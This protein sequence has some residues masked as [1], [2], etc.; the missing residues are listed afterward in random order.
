MYCKSY[1]VPFVAGME[2]FAQPRHALDP[3]APHSTILQRYGVLRRAQLP[4]RPA[5]GEA[6]CAGRFCTEQTNR[7][8]SCCQEERTAMVDEPA[9]APALADEAGAAGAADAAAAAAG[10][11]DTPLTLLS[12]PLLSPS[13]GGGASVTEWY[14]RPTART[15]ASSQTTST[16][17]SELTE[18]LAALELARLRADEQREQARWQAEHDR[19]E[20]TRRALEE[21]EGR[22]REA[23]SAADAMRT[24]LGK[25]RTAESERSAELDVALASL[26]EARQLAAT[27]ASDA[28]HFRGQA[29]TLAAT[30]EALT[31][32]SERQAE[33]LRSLQA[34]TSEQRQAL[35]SAQKAYELTHLARHH[36][37]LHGAGSGAT[38]A[39]DRM[40][41]APSP[42]LGSPSTPSGSGRADG[43]VAS[44]LPTD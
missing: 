23:E 5:C 32:H 37:Q 3:A 36:A 38:A 26:K 39:V 15:D 13:S 7:S 4:P 19:F 31:A 41:L 42:S 9:P 30:L 20:A 2:R 40:L 33:V 11:T 34:E 1:Y 22:A 25:A 27:R 8:V 44:P 16:P 18:R 10:A 24:E 35:S 12:Q 28:S 43:G 17:G 21:A 14:Q 6:K 29:A